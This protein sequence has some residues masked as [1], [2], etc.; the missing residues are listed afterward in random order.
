[1]NLEG[2][3]K[4][5]P[6]GKRSD[7][8]LSKRLEIVSL[9]LIGPKMPSFGGTRYILSILD[10][11]SRFGFAYLQSQTTRE[12]ECWLK[13]VERKTRDKVLTIQTDNGSKFM[14]NQFQSILKSHGIAHRL[15]APYRPMQNSFI[16]H[17]GQTLQYMSE[18]MLLDSGL[19]PKFWGE[20]VLCAN[21]IMNVV[22]HHGIGNTPYFYRAGRKPNLDYLY[23]FGA[24]AFVHVPKVLR[25]K[26][27]IKGK[28][29]VFSGLSIK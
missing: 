27:A 24:P 4:C 14:C 10:Q 16:E 15:S 5:A 28:K 23:P 2:K 17:R 1:M 13:Y 26:R 9:A 19:S 25:Y 6:V 21:F 8:K 29:A 12:F 18:T 3:S 20:S 7:V 11:Y 22:F